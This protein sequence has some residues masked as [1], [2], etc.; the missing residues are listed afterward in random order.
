MAQNPI[1]TMT[2]EERLVALRT[3]E[4]G[5]VV[6]VTEPVRTADVPETGTFA[7]EVRD[8]GDVPRPVLAPVDDADEAGDLPA[9]ELTT[10]DERDVLEVPAPLV[11][12]ELGLDAAAYDD[13]NPLLFE[14]DE[15]TEGI[16]VGTAQDGEAGGTVEVAL[17]LRPVRFADGTPYRDVP[18]SESSLDSDPVAEAAIERERGDDATPQSGTLTAPVDAP[19]VDDV[20]DE[21]G[22][23]RA[24]VVDALESMARRDLVSVADDDS[25]QEPL[26]ADDRAVVALDDEDWESV[27]M[28]L[29]A[30]DA[31]LEAVRDTHARQADALLDRSDADGERFAG[32]TPVV[33]QPDRRYESDE[34]PD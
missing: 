26:V 29:D 33:I 34:P 12:D 24:A 32:R 17:E 21:T 31:T 14:P 4:D 8:E 7:W 1:G 28:E 27:T 20:L 25:S 19:F 13:E 3:R 6:D 11:V 30:D 22:A 15:L 5:F 2:D 10:V 18:L 23:S 9:R 16:P